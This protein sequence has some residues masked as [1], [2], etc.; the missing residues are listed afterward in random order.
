MGYLLRM[1]IF[2]SVFLVGSP[3]ISAQDIIPPKDFIAITGLALDALDE[4]EVVFSEYD[5]RKFEAKAAFK[6][7]DIVMKKYDRYIEKWP[8]GEQKE[9]VWSIQSSRLLFEMAMELSHKED[10]QKAKQ[11]AQKARATFTQYKKKHE[12]E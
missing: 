2:L 5:S 1:L 3:A 8:D 11:Q 4:I 12:R 7:C 6:K 10:L 9:I